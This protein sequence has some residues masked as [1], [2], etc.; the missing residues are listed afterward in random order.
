MCFS[1]VGPIN[2]GGSHKCCQLLHV[3]HKS[4]SSIK[5]IL[6]SSISASNSTLLIEED[7]PAENDE[8]WSGNID[9]P[10]IP[11][12]DQKF[13]ISL[14]WKLQPSVNID[15]STFVKVVSKKLFMC[16]R[17]FQLIF[18]G[19]LCFWTVNRVFMESQRK[20][21]LPGLWN[22]FGFLVSFFLELFCKRSLFSP[23]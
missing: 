4:S 11:E 23:M 12:N 9:G 2:G 15:F 14:N 5:T 20:V 22:I 10:K 13:D 17:T 6:N 8:A 3:T 19:F 7:F 18:F 16:G 1:L 21:K